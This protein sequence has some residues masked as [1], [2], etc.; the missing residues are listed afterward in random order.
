MDITKHLGFLEKEYGFQLEHLFF[1]KEASNKIETFS[2]HNRYGCFTIEKKEGVPL[3]FYYAPRFSTELPELEKEPI[4]ITMTRYK[5][6][7]LRLFP[8]RDD[9]VLETL[10]DI[11]RMEIETKGCVFGIAVTRS[12][13]KSPR[14]PTA[15][16]L[17][18]A[19]KRADGHLKRKIDKQL[20]SF[21]RLL[22]TFLA[23]DLHRFLAFIGCEIEKAE[24]SD[25]DWQERLSLSFSYR[26]ARI[27]CAF[28][29]DSYTCRI[30][31]NRTNI[32]PF[33]GKQAYQKG[34]SLEDAVDKM[35]TAVD[36]NSKGDAFYDLKDKFLPN[37]PGRLGFINVE[38]LLTFASI[39]LSTISVLS[40][41]S[42][43]GKMP[44]LGFFFFL[45]LVATSVFYLAVVEVMRLNQ[46][47]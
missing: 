26:R 1:G 47:K 46:R 22:K 14:L 21:D 5:E 20:D 12:R 3:E 16:W 27:D 28:D 39:L 43:R 41:F 23:G 38:S 8:T 9:K 10:G 40:C 30:F 7:N 17:T 42:E 37:G 15:P 29:R 35:L 45:A 44:D 11:M 25:K 18:A 31:K 34:F 24:Y 19:S 6:W 13:P 36:N 2:F 32:S 4:D 33:P